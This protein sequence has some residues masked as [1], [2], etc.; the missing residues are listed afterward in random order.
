MRIFPFKRSE[1][2]QTVVVLN[3]EEFSQMIAEAIAT[4]LGIDLENENISFYFSNDA[5]HYTL[6]SG[7]SKD[8][9]C[10]INF[11]ERNNDNA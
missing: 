3:S 4:K 5:H 7:K 6:A 1:G 2:K 9:G 10:A 11:L 8:Y